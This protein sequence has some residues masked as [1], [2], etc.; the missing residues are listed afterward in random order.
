M[1]KKI[2]ENGIETNYSVSDNGE[3]RNDTTLQILKQ[4]LEYGYYT[5]RLYIRKVGLKG[6]KSS[7]ISCGGIF[8]QSRK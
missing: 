6:K 2:Y 8:T 1:L 7:Q 4:Y 3:V 5:V